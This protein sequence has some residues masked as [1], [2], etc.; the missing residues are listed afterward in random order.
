MLLPWLEPGAIYACAGFDPAE[1]EAEREAVSLF[2]ELG[3]A[4][5]SPWLRESAMLR[6]PDIEPLLRR[7]ASVTFGQRSIVVITRVAP[8]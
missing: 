5:V 4:A 2:A 8:E 6:S 3:K 1:V 7:V